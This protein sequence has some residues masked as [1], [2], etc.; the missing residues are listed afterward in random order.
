MQLFI[1]THSLGFIKMKTTL[2]ICVFIL[3]SASIALSVTHTIIN[4]G[5]TFSPSALTINQ[6]DTVNFV[7]GSLHDAIEVSQATWNAN[8]TTSNGGFQVP[9]GGGIV[10]SLSQGTHYYVCS[11]H[12]LLG[13]KGTITVNLSS[14]VQ[15]I[16]NKLPSSFKLSQNFPNPFNPSTSISYSI[17]QPSFISLK[18][19][20]IL[21]EEV[22]TLIESESA[23]GRYEVI[24][25]GST[26]SSGMYFYQLKA[27]SISNNSNQLFV[28][29][30]RLLLIK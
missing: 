25:N 21:G 2:L 20:N 1:S 6:G 16:D 23:P 13:M 5:F 26:Q 29:T 8:G 9:F 11:N 14:G 19:F 30:K 27:K 18:I 10:V 15:T 17:A 7:L 4:S 22:E 12:V 28:E 3:L 24:W